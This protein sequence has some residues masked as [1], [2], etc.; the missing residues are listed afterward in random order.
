MVPK[1]SELLPDPETPVKAVSRRLGISTST[2][3]RLFTRATRTRIRSWRSAACSRDD[4][5]GSPV[6]GVP[7]SARATVR[8]PVV[9]A[10]RIAGSSPGWRM[11]AVG[12]RPLLDPDQVAGRVA[13]GA[14]ADAVGL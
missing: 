2:S 12:S 1:T 3:L 11:V 4:V 8:G 7:V 5:I 10:A 9:A 13:E 6:D 14:V